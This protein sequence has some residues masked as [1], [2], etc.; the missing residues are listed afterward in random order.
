MAVKT[1]RVLSTGWQFAQIH[2]ETHEPVEWMPV[3]QIPT[4]VHQELKLLGKI[5]DPVIISLSTGV[6]LIKRF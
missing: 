2:E 4:S 5:Q 1:C 6:Y 3:S